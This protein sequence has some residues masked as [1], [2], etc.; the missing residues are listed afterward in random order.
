M[1]ILKMNLIF[2]M[3]M[4]VSP[5]PVKPNA[6]GVARSADEALNVGRGKVTFPP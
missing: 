2:K 4:A 6:P 3:S 5:G 1:L